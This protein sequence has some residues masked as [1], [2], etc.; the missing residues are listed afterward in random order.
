M[1]IRTH[2]FRFSVTD[3]VRTATCIV[4]FR[5]RALIPFAYMTDN[6]LF[7]KI[8]WLLTLNTI[9]NRIGRKIIIF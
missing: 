5:D 2:H 3:R 9:V 1:D 4:P 7:I 8:V 6:N